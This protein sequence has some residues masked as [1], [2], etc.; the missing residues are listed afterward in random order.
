MDCSGKGGATSGTL[1]NI[2]SKSGQINFHCRFCDVD[3]HSSYYCNKHKTLDQRKDRC[4]V[5]ELCLKCTSNKHVAK[6]CPC[7]S[8]NILNLYRYCNIKGHI[9]AIVDA[10]FTTGVT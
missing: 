5:L 2:H 4:I 8:R 1:D 3:D 9:A 7:K 10:C 6:T